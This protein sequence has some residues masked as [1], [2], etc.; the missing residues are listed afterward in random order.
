MA[1]NETV[2]DPKPIISLMFA[3]SV[4]FWAKQL[5]QY[6]AA[7]EIDNQSWLILGSGILFLVDLL[8]VAWWY[9]R[10]IYRVQPNASFGTYFLD[11]IICS[12]FALA[13]NSWTKPFTFLLATVFGTTFII[14][15]FFLLYFSPSVSLTDKYILKRAG[16]I[17][18][19]ALL[20]AVFGLK[21][22]QS[23]WPWLKAESPFKLDMHSF[24]GLLSL[25][26]IVLTLHLRRRIDVAVDIYSAKHSSVPAAHLTWPV[27]PAKGSSPVFL[28]FEGL[29]TFAEEIKK[30]AFMVAVSHWLDDLVDGRNEV[31]VWKQ[32]A[33]GLH[34]SEDID[35]AKTLFEQ[36]YRP[37]VIKHTNRK[38]YAQLY[39][40]VNKCCLHSYNLK[41][42]LLGLNRIAYGSVI[43]SPK[44]PHAQRWEL[45][46]EKH[47]LFLKEWNVETK[48]EFEKMVEDIIDQITVG[49]ENEAGPILLGLTTKTVQEIAL[50]SENHELNV[51][52]SILF[53][54]LYAPL[55]YYHNIIP[56]LKNDEMVHLQA[57]D[58]DYYLWIPWLR[59]VRKAIDIAWD[60]N[61]VGNKEIVE[62]KEMRVKQ[63]EMA[64]RCFE[65]MLPDHIKRR[66]REIYIPKR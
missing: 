25:I 2:I 28:R 53:S 40:M 6:I 29:D 60:N 46:N 54:I 37:L 4:G 12:M 45:L 7:N 18:I 56:E 36:I 8:C 41:Y 59:R 51:S 23:Q 58:T 48:G 11:F 43:F 35:K 66:L 38:F 26:G 20:I 61:M 57:F 33:N 47:N 32:L 30:K 65:P 64:Y 10:Y 3:I 31:F 15:R 63:I 55:I 42:M 49:E 34:L 27:T 24:P 5:A 21:V 19:I 13:A 52:L 62:R 22:P 1:I 14:C 39:E 9:A 50:S 17:L 16:L 44:I